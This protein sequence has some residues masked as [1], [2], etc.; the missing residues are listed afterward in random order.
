MSCVDE[1]RERLMTAFAPSELEVSDDSRQHA[2]HAGAAGGGGH[3]AVLIVSERFRGRSLLERH[4]LVY[5]AL[6][7]LRKG[8]HALSIRALVPGDI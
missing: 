3:Y 6:E 7:P 5:A 2:G 4:R 8:I 1:I